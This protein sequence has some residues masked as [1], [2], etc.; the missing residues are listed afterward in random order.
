MTDMNA[1]IYLC[2]Y[3]WLHNSMVDA[4]TEEALAWGEITFFY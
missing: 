4:L 3:E 1:N 2:I